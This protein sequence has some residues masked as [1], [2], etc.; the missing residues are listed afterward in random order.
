MS[1]MPPVNDLFLSAWMPH[2]ESG[3][4]PPESQIS[5]DKS[6]VCFILVGHW[7]LEGANGSEIGS[8]KTLST[9]FFRLSKYPYPRQAL[10]P[11][12]SIRNDNLV[13][14]SIC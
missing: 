9:T 3:I 5:T 13:R 8:T 6:T 14:A 10:F 11:I 1:V 12:H 2:P 7:P 4:T